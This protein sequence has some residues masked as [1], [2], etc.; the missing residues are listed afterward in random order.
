MAPPK[1]PPLF[2]FGLLAA[3]A[4]TWPASLSG[5]ALAQQTSPA[6]AAQP[7]DDAFTA[8]ELKTLL[9]PYALYPDDL[10]AQVLPACAYPIEIVQVSRWLAKNKDA[11]ADGN[12]SG[13]DDQSWDDSVKA[14]ARFPDVLAKLNDNLDATTGLPPLGG[15]VEL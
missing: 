3:L 5:I 8:A 15:P 7:A 2:A 14:L 13:L 6:A 9:A 11:V 4:T 12:Y 1:T 10:L